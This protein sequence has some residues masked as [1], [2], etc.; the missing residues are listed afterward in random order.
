MGRRHRRSG[1][2]RVRRAAG[3]AL[4]VVLSSILLAA[5]GAPAAS[6]HVLLAA[7]APAD[8][9][10]VEEAPAEV[11]LTFTEVP[12]P[13]L[14][15]VH[16][17]DAAGRRVE[18]ARAA[19]VPGEP[20]SVRIPLEA[21]GPA[22][23]T[24][25]WRTSVDGHTTA[26]AVAF[27]VGVPA[28]PPG[29]AAGPSAGTSP[30]PSAAGVAGRWLFSVGVVL[31]LGAA[32]VGV[33]VVA[34]PRA[35]PRWA[36]GAAWV[37]AAGGLLLTITDQRANAQTGLANLLSSDT[38]HKL[39]TQ[40]IA[41]LLTGAA[42][43]WACFRRTRAAL[44]A[45]GAG[46]GAAMLARA[47]A[48]HAGASSARWFTVGM[49]WVHLVAVGV[50]VGGLV[51]LL[52][53]MRSGDPG[54]GAGLVRRF[55]TVAGWSL[56][57]VVISGMA[58]AID[59]VGAWGRLFST[60]YGVALV[61]KVGLVAILVALGARSRFG[62]VPASP[63]LGSGR[64]RRLVRGEVAFGAA[65]LVAA[66]AL[67]GFPPSEVVAAASRVAP[68]A[69]GNITVSGSD[70]ATSVRVN[71][72][73]S[74]GLPGPNH[75]DA[76]VDDYATG[77]ALAAEGVS[78]RLQPQEGTDAR[79]ATLELTASADGHWRGFG[80][81]LAVPGRWNVT[82]IVGTSTGSVEVPMEVQTRTPATGSV[83]RAGD[84]GCGDGEVDAAYTATVDS[85]P[86]PPRTEGT[87]FRITLRR[88]G[89]PVTGAKVCFAADMPDM[90]H[91]GVSR[92]ARETS[93][94]RYE[95][96]LKFE[97]GGAWAASVI[98]AE[99]GRPV[100]LVRVRLFVR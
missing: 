75:F 81:G 6:A 47:L 82:V 5:W 74:P 94:G 29:T 17:L 96:D 3:T 42:V 50:W 2:T 59:A 88:D 83:D 97:M 24:V 87:K 100:A 61:V 67:A 64:L 49:Q 9:E 92:V 77:E 16:V 18:A 58:R 91:P 23:Y 8:G 84:A 62:H 78:L 31:L 73:V 90:Q 51:W 71:L 38:G 34:R 70:V 95:V 7:S 32:A 48:G 68:A 21:L 36:L 55:S 1:A 40:G 44:A 22:V 56:A 54:R 53:A 10:T 37:V 26:G 33:A 65:V 60:D 52:F 19:P 12:D 79:E 45:V 72:V 57:V 39:I 76:T 30:A 99:P 66:A 28:P 25:T 86:D 4:A 20:H 43:A 13:A 85:D 46:A 35:V 98:V 15:T 89:R 63:A 14:T 93:G 69:T 80:R 27:G 11:V 41:L